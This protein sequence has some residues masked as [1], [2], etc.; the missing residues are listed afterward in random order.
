MAAV[1]SYIPTPVR[2]LDKPFLM[3]IESVYSLP[4]RGT[5]VTGR[6]ERGTVKK[7]SDCEFVGYNDKSIKTTVTGKYNPPISY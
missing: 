4:G 7:G 2:D 1:D 3:P 6:L 5:V